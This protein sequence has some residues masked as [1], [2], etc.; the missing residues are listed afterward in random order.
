MYN[1]WYMICEDLLKW[2]IDWS[3]ANP[4]MAG[5]E[6]EIQGSS[7]FSVQEAD[8]LSWFSV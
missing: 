8:Y 7:N 5:S 2:L 4:T 1:I 6:L 3:S